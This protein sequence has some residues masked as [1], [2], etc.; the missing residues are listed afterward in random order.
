MAPFYGYGPE[1][2]SGGFVEKSAFCNIGRIDWRDKQKGCV[3][4][5][6]AT[7]RGGLG[8]INALAGP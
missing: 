7:G 4:R 3:Y 2:I 5:L 6:R 8:L 1:N